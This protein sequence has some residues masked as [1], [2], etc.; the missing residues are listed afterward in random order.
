MI[1]NILATYT[2]KVTTGN[3]IFTKP[4]DPNRSAKAAAQ[5]T[6]LLNDFRDSL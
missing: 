3:N 6:D 1:K 2:D 4:V 5:V